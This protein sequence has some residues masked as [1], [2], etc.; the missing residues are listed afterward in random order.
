M[1]RS[2]YLLLLLYADNGQPIKGRL[3]LQKLAFLLQE[4]VRESRLQISSEK[5]TFKPYKFG[6]FTVDVMDDIYLLKLYGLV[7]IEESNDTEIYK[8]TAQ[9]KKLIDSIITQIPQRLLLRIERIKREFGR[10]DD[11]EILEYVYRNWPEY[12]SKSVLRRGF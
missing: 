7:D 11:K 4:A 8:I 2:I 12:A 3:R 1:D 6:P 10:K 5:Y 9:G